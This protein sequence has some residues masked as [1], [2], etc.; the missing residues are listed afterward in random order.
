MI[1]TGGEFKGRKIACPAGNDV[2]P[3][4]SKTRQAIF[5]V[6]YSMGIDVHDTAVLELFSGTGIMSFEAI[7]RG[8]Q[9]A[10]LVDNSHNALVCSQKNIEHLNITD[11][12]K[13]VKQD[14][15]EY[16]NYANLDNV[17]ILYIDPPYRYEKYDELLKVLFSKINNDAIVML[18]SKYSVIDEDNQIN[19]SIIK[20]KSWG[21]AFVTFMKKANG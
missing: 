9:R 18:E 21:K 20:T 2:R 10:T 8:A 1:V 7:S 16:L 13:V 17:D 11:K 19:A 5:N 14:A 15:I 12:V 6:L 3:T 4:S